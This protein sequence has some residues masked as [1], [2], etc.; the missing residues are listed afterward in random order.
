MN[1]VVDINT[2]HKNRPSI[3]VREQV[4]NRA[5]E[6]VCMPVARLSYNSK[7]EV[8]ITPS[9]AIMTPDDA[10]T[11]ARVLQALVSFADVVRMG[12]GDTEHATMYGRMLHP[13]RLA[14]NGEEQTVS[15]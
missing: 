10:S 9:S 5:N 11:V 3:E 14:V 7:G 1:L 15:W 12:F 13:E 2:D 6:L 8:T 4:L